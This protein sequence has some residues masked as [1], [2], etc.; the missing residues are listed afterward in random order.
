MGVAFQPVFY[1]AFANAGNNALF[2]GGYSFI[3]FF[4]FFTPLLLH[5]I[6][7]KYVS[8][9]EYNEKDDIYIA[10]TYNFFCMTKE[11]STA[12]CYVFKQI[13]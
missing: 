6:T 8:Q 2:I 3:A 11:V 9:L 13:C 5:F 10:K 4:T 1:N 7:K 12:L